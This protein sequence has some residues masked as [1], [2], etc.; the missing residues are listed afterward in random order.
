MKEMNMGKGRQRN[1]ISKQIQ[2]DARQ[3]NKK[4]HDKARQKQIPKQKLIDSEG[5]T[6]AELA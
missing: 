5:Q 2:T 1:T 3:R 6:I 4:E